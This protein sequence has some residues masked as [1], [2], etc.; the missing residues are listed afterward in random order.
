MSPSIFKNLVAACKSR[1]KE[2]FVAN[3]KLLQENDNV[4]LADAYGDTVAHHCYKHG[5]LEGVE[6]LLECGLTTHLRN[7]ME[8]APLHYACQYD[9]TEMIQWHLERNSLEEEYSSIDYASG[10]TPAMWLVSNGNLRTLERFAALGYADPNQA[11]SYRKNTMFTLAIQHAQPEIAWFLWKNG[12]QGDHGIDQPRLNGSS[13]ARDIIVYTKEPARMFRLMEKLGK[14]HML[15][16]DMEEEGISSLMYCIEMKRFDAFVCM[17]KYGFARPCGEYDVVRNFESGDVLE[18][19]MKKIREEIG[20]YLDFVNGFLIGTIVLPT[21]P[22]KKWVRRCGLR[23]LESGNNRL[24]A[25]FAG[26]PYGIVL[27][28]LRE[29]HAFLETYVT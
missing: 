13:I 21:S 27:M 19:F 20:R 23:A 26:I 4:S 6:F 9:H 5:Y 14:L 8:A 12:L 29:A 18:S 2:R 1:N 16:E 28:Y 15:R 25:D 11:T 17:V 3:V 7:S 24:I 10:F 22:K